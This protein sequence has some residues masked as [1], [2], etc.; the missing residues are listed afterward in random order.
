MART[1]NETRITP[2]ILDRLLDFAPDITREPPTSRAKSLRE[3]KQSVRR[4]LEWLLN[5]RN[6]SDEIAASLEEVSKS[7]VIYGLADFTGQ[8]VKSPGEQ[9][10]LV[11]SLEKAIRV[12]EPRLMDLRVSLEP[13]DDIKRILHFRIEARLKVDP[14]P[15]PVMFDTVLQMGSGQFEIIEK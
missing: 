5:T 4:D 15:E 9:K 3:L 6:H 14:A 11:Q 13:I 2:S 1:D 7:L 10:K 12:F 8:G